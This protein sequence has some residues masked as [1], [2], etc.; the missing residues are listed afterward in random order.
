MNEQTTKAAGTSPEPVVEDPAATP[1]AP[2]VPRG[3]EP[4]AIV[5]P[6]KDHSA[7][8]TVLGG[9]A[10]RS[11]EVGRRRFATFLAVVIA[12]LMGGMVY[13]LVH[14][15]DE[16]PSKEQMIARGLAVVTL[17]VFSTVLVKA[18]DRLLLPLWLV[19]KLASIEANRSPRERALV[20]ATKT[21]LQFAKDLKE[22]MAS[23]AASKE[24][25]AKGRE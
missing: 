1:P 10:D 13:F 8:S 18:A 2:L 4:A 6:P 22:L 3:A 9:P 16:P 11:A 12:G 23:E 5:P 24:P 14:I 20:G 17:G 21:V 7:P 15:L 19:E 25:P